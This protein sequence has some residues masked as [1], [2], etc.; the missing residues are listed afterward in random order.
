MVSHAQDVAVGADSWSSLCTVDAWSLSAR[1]RSLS[2]YGEREREFN[3]YLIQWFHC[4]G[5]MFII[6]SNCEWCSLILVSP[7]CVTRV[8]QKKRR[9]HQC[10]SKDRNTNMS[11][12]CWWSPMGEWWVTG[13]GL[14]LSATQS[15]VIVDIPIVF[16][17]QIPMV[18]WFRFT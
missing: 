12:S 8:Q 16:L 7:W 9:C 11:P 1:A 2:L 3:G 15:W 6:Y 13:N 10:S 5:W 4:T 17:V 14:M 18:W